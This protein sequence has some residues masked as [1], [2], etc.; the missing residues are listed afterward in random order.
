MSDLLTLKAG[1]QR[2][3]LDPSLGTIRDLR[4]AHAGRVLNPLHRAPWLDEAEVQA[5][6]SLLPV[7][8]G[9]SGDFF[10]A[11]FGTDGRQDPPCHGWAANSAWTPLSQTEELRLTL[12][13]TVFGAQ[14]TKRL[15]LAEGPLLIQEHRLTGGA[16]ATTVAH[17]P[18]VRLHG[19]GRLSISPKQRA[20]T[21]E[22]PLE[23]AH[24]LRYPAQT[25]TPE[26]F[27][28]EDGTIDLTRLPIGMGHEDFVTLVEAQGSPLGWTAVLREAEDDVVFVL[29]D[30][31]VLPITMLW[32]SNGG[33]DRAPWN[34]RHRGVL[35]IED[36]CGEGAGG[37]IAALGPNPVRGLGARTVLALAP[38]RV[39]VIRHVIGAIARPPGW[40]RVIDIALTEAGLTL[41]GTAGD[42]VVLDFD[43]SWLFGGVAHGVLGPA[44]RTDAP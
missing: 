3:T 11:P 39:H 28:G 41:T 16:G 29:K 23:P 37:L 35:G 19:K 1:A 21:P 36:G 38:G 24:M 17:H 15:R 6:M 7:E 20:M 2:V 30:P 4:L 8:R 9:L 14:V 26:S 42:P 32:Y 18:M 22:A 44:S 13:R 5:D 33:R 10:C 31:A 40:T 12:Q 25:E 34:G 27:P 43:R